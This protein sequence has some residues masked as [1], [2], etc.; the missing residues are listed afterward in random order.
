M[1]KADWPTKVF[2]QKKELRKMYELGDDLATDV[3][4]HIM[5][6][7]RAIK[8]G[9]PRQTISLLITTRQEDMGD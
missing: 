5:D 9:E 8:K 4:T 7:L 6:A 2:I 3:K 1:D